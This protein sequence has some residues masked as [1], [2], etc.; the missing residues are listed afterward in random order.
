VD[1]LNRDGFGPL[2]QI[3]VIERRDEPLPGPSSSRNIPPHHLPEPRNLFQD[4]DLELPRIA[5]LALPPERS[6]TT[7]AP[8]SAPTLPLIRPA[9]EQQA[10]QRKRAVTFPGKGAR[11]TTNAGPKVVACNFCRGLFI[12]L[13][14]ATCLLTVGMICSTQNEMRRCAS[15]VRELRSQVPTM[16]LRA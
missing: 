12:P 13:P 15:G 14:S 3:N 1:K 16:Q 4:G 11:Q 5:T 7:P 9:S 2:P 10:A 8:M 6:P